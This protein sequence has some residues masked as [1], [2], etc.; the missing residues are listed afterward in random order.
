MS[1]LPEHV[2]TFLHDLEARTPR[3]VEILREVIDRFR[4]TCDSC[5]IEIKY[6]GVVFLLDGELIGGVFPYK[7][8]V[9]VE[10]SHGAAFRDDSRVLQG[11]G[12]HRR[13]IKLQSVDDL[14]RVP[15]DSYIQQAVS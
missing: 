1:Q 5:S 2:E 11:S 3:F 7:A 6:G 4:A 12:A 14:S 9:S 15:L 8:H 13:H 10:F